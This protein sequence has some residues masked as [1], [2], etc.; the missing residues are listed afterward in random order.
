MEPTCSGTT[1]RGLAVTGLAMSRR[2]TPRGQTKCAETQTTLFVTRPRF[3]LR[4]GACASSAMAGRG[5]TLGQTKCDETQTSALQLVP[6]DLEL[7]GAAEDLR[8]GPWLVVRRENEIDHRIVCVEHHLVEPT[9]G[10]SQRKPAS[11]SRSS[12]RFASSRCRMK[13]TSCDDSVPPRAETARP[14]ASAN[15][16]SLS[17][18]VAAA[19]FIASSS[20]LKEASPGIRHAWYP[21]RSSQILIQAPH[22]EDDPGGGGR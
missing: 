4:S 1:A 8:D 12:A 19:R 22:G 3:P 2:A 18:N 10:R 16:I 14:P 6:V 13:S 17:R 21:D 7:V 5:T 11:A 15:S 20:V 9:L